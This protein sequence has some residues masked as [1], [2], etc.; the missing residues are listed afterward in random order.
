[1]LYWRI[2]ATMVLCCLLR[3]G[4]CTSSQH[5]SAALTPYVVPGSS[6]DG[7]KGGT[8]ILDNTKGATRLPFVEIY[9]GRAFNYKDPQ[10]YNENDLKHREE[11]LEK[12][13]GYETDAYETM[14]NF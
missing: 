3:H 11:Q 1:M 10:D 14:H 7:S 8:V 5:S 12:L 2:S 13:Q 9:G 4:Y 6:S